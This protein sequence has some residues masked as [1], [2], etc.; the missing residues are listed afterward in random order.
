MQRREKS[1]RRSSKSSHVNCNRS[2]HVTDEHGH[3]IRVTSDPQL[4]AV[5][6]VPLRR[7]S[8]EAV[9]ERNILAGDEMKSIA[10]ASA[11]NRRPFV[12]RTLSEISS[13]ASLDPI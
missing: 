8:H 6:A 12:I 13:S 3:Q 1:E 7:V 2:F 5:Y 9:K 11:F 4:S 10:A